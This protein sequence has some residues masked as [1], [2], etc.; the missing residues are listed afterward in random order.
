[1]EVVAKLKHS[2]MAITYKIEGRS[3]G[4]IDAIE[5]LAGDIRRLRAVISYLEQRGENSDHS[6]YITEI[7]ELREHLDQVKVQID[8]AEQRQRTISVGEELSDQPIVK[9]LY[10]EEANLGNGDVWNGYKAYCHDHNG[11]LYIEAIRS[12]IIEA[13]WLTDKLIELSLSHPRPKIFATPL[14]FVP[15]GHRDDEVRIGDVAVLV[16]QYV[17]IG[18]VDEEHGGS[19]LSMTNY[20][21]IVSIEEQNLSRRSKNR[22]AELETQT[23]SCFR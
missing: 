2:T 5:N 17:I 1:M 11:Y 12:T 21:R 6:F 4:R 10:P 16:G 9:C 14:K 18:E 8:R 3:I 20:L 23:T 7:R 15:E 22:A 19:P 13:R